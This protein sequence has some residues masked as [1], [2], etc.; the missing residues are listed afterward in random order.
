MLFIYSW[1]L[2]IMGGM[3]LLAY[4]FPSFTYCCT[5]LH[6]PPESSC[7]SIVVLSKMCLRYGAVH[8]SMEI[9]GK[10]W[11]SPFWSV[12]VTSNVAKSSLDHT[13]KLAQITH[14]WQIIRWSGFI[15]IWLQVQLWDR[16]HLGCCPKKGFRLGECVPIG[17]SWY[18]CGF[19]YH[20]AWYPSADPVWFRIGLTG[21]RVIPLFPFGQVPEGGIGLLLLLPLAFGL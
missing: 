4:R 18:F 13:L 21:P 5:H 7:L 20:Q 12:K 6:P 15:S 16:N 19:W 11:R 17:P 10:N 14:W 9:N 3:L 1:I 8:V 2:A